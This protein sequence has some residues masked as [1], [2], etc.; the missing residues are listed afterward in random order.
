M[1]GKELGKIRG[2]SVMDYLNEHEP[3]TMVEDGANEW[4]HKDHDSLKFSNGMF[5]WFSRGIGGRSALDY[6]IK[7]E[8]MSFMDAVNRLIDC[9]PE[10]GV[11]PI[12]KVP[13]QPNLRLPRAYENNGSV[14]AYLESRGISRS[15][16][17]EVID[18]K[19]L[20]ENARYHSAVFVGY[21]D[22]G[23]ARY[24]MYRS[25]SNE[26]DRRVG[27]F[28]GSEKEFAFRIVTS[29]MKEVHLFESAIDLLSYATLLEIDGEDWTKY[30]LVSTGGVTLPRTDKEHVIEIDCVP[31]VLKRIINRESDLKVIHCHFDNDRAG[32]ACADAL[33]ELLSDNYIVYDDHAP[34]G[35]DYND[36]LMIC[37]KAE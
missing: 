3:G 18:R 19:M 12:A 23:N 26:P 17:D 22:E 2:I 28:M 31:P 1:T 33:Y 7:V 25:T 21:D 37:L 10:M 35:K 36:Y 24:G 14:I 34:E 9:Y 8:N 4:H 16:I 20:Y 29:P 32:Q 15:V 5:N 30:N 11:F 6:L 13:V 27:E